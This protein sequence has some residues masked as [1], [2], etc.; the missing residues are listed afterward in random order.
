M[1]FP[2]LISWTSTSVINLTNIVAYALDGVWWK[3]S[4][5]CCRCASS[6]LEVQPGLWK[7]QR[8]M[9]IFTS[10]LQCLLAS[11]LSPI[12][13]FKRVE[14]A[15][16][17]A[18]LC[19]GGIPVALFS[20][21]KL[22]AKHKGDSQICW[23]AGLLGWPWKK[24]S[25][26]RSEINRK[27]EAPGLQLE[28]LSLCTRPLCVKL[29]DLIDFLGFISQPWSPHT[30]TLLSDHT[31]FLSLLFFF[32]NIYFFQTDLRWVKIHNQE[33]VPPPADTLHASR[34]LSQGPEVSLRGIF[35][36]RDPF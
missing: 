29:S 2:F 20:P 25:P 34:C 35:L 36:S 33:E 26:R 6:Y 28:I 30:R 7:L 13:L 10:R 21:T 12:S 4:E 18:N 19:K 15:L 14:L 3:R 16:V 22:C 8:G 1:H 9:A 5:R 17:K 31:L 11:T 32:L 27:R 23:D 24:V